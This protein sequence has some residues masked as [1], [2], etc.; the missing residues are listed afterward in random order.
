MRSTPFARSRAMFAAIAAA[1]AG[2]NAQATIAAMAPYRS[3]GHG[4]GKAFDKRR[5]VSKS[6]KYRPHQGARECLRRRV[7][8]FAGGGAAVALYWE[9]L[10]G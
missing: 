4:R 7:G 2:P 3:R 8:G 10:N 9:M 1:M 6:G 5:H